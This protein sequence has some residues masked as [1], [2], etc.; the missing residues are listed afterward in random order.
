MKPTYPI[1]IKQIS[2][3]DSLKLWLDHVDYHASRQL[4]NRAMMRVL[5]LAWDWLLT[6]TGIEVTRPALTCASYAIN[7]TETSQKRLPEQVQLAVFHNTD[8]ANRASQTG[9]NGIASALSAATL[10]ATSAI[11]PKAQL[12]RAVTNTVTSAAGAFGQKMATPN[13]QDKV[14]NQFWAEVQADC[15]L[16]L[17]GQASDLGPIW[18]TQQPPF[19]AE[20]QNIIT[21]LDGKPEWENWLKWYQTFEHG[22]PFTTDLLT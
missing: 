11:L 20:M 16:I 1:D 6:T 17:E 19:D 8:Y 4:A 18:H 15:K 3:K 12:V 10:A 22:M 5:P 13:T 2:D 7:A 21:K 9:H 14:E